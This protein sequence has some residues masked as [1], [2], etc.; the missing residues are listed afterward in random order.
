MAVTRDGEAIHAQGR[1]VIPLADTVGAGDGFVAVYILGTL[2]QWP[3]NTTLNR[4]NE[5]A[6]A[7]CA[8]RGTA[9]DENDF[10][11]PFLREWKL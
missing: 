4:A 9:S 11:A 5:F 2:N 6:A 10:Y 7:I 3:A 1:S 8:I